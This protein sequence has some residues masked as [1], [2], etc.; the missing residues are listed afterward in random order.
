MSRLHS[1]YV[2]LLAITMVLMTGAFSFQTRSSPLLATPTFVPQ[3]LPVAEKMR[4]LAGQPDKVLELALAALDPKKT[5]W[6]E[7]QIRQRLR[8]DGFAFEADSRL[9]LGPNHC[10]RLDTTLRNGM[11][12]RIVVVSDG[13]F[14]AQAFHLPPQPQRT[15][16]WSLPAAPAE[17]NDPA[18][19]RERDRLLFE[20][21]C[22]GPYPLL[23]DL[24]NRLKD[25]QV[26]TGV[27]ADKAVFCCSGRLDQAAAIAKELR[28]AR[29]AQT[30]QLFLD[31]QTMLPVRIE[32]WAG[33]R[34]LLELEY[35]QLK[36]NQPLTHEQCVKEFTFGPG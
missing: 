11:P 4:E 28:Y 17:N 25:L 35:R 1:F 30:C 34:L 36:I 20:K 8:D 31:A 27:L 26:T 21:G 16:C 22:G 3:T 13:T 32:W 18:I 33:G 24:R 12:G 23:L 14:M 9:V 10:A 6:L 2:P 15:S 5:E 29:N 19:G 7:V